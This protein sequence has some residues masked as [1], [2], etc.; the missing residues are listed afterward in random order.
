MALSILYILY[1]QQQEDASDLLIYQVKTFF[2]DW[3]FAMDF[4][5][6]IYSQYKPF[7]EIANF[8]VNF[9]YREFFRFNLKKILVS[10]K[11][12]HVES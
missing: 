6:G 7:H 5:K 8:W 3:V 12:N 11:C 2:L 10:A 1:L 4:T 9:Y